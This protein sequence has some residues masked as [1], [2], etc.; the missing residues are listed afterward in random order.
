MSIGHAVMVSGVALVVIAIALRSWPRPGTLVLP[1]AGGAILDARLP[2]VPEIHGLL[3]RVLVVLVASWLMG[4]G[5]A[6]I[7]RAAVGVAAY[8]AVML[9]LRRLS[10]YPLAPI[11]VA[12]ELAML[13]CG[14]LLG[15][16]VGA[17][18]VVTGL[19]IG[20]AIQ[21]WLSV[22]TRVDG[23]LSSFAFPGRRSSR[24]PRQAWRG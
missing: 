7:I 18:T 1:F 14:W 20:P 13:L 23:R 4:L 19:L 8:D 9:G 2:S 11:R 6:R 5:G 17:G 24:R 22:L 16:R 10:G 3:W 12:M 21:F 15:G